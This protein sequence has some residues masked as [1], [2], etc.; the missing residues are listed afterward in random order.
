MNKKLGVKKR[1]MSFSQSYEYDVHNENG[2]LVR[3]ISINEWKEEVI[4]RVFSV[5]SECTW[6]IFHDKDT[7][8]VFDSDT[9][10]FVEE[11]V[12]IHYHGIFIFKN[13]R[14]MSSIAELIETEQIEH[15]RDYEGHLRYLT[16][17]TENAMADKKYRYGIDELYCSE[18]NKILNKEEVRKLYT[19][20]ISIFK[21]RK[22]NEL[23]RFVDEVERKIMNGELSN[24]FEIKELFIGK[25]GEV[26]NNH[27]RRY[28][29]RFNEAQEIYIEDR[30][31]FV[32]KRGRKLVT[33]YIY[34]KSNLGKTTLGEII[35]K[36]QSKRN[37]FSES[38]FYFGATKSE[39]ITKDVFQQYKSQYSTILDE[40]M[41]DEYFGYSQFNSVFNQTTMTTIGS[42]NVNRKW[43]SEFC[44]IIKSNGIDE[45]INNM[46]AKASVNEKKDME[47]V[48]KQ[49][50]RRIPI[51]VELLETGITV[52]VYDK[53]INDYVLKKEYKDLLILDS[54]INEINR[55]THELD[56]L[57]EEVRDNIKKDRHFEI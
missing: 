30:V 23:N 48:R 55:F 41:P 54:D 29:S 11:E 39:G 15:L 1:K 13:N 33:V 43:C 3:D 45:L 10:E 47:N 34:G 14:Y 46:C 7:K 31:K 53:K 19:E 21:N 20:N 16:H 6:L 52:K 9:N 26:G 49:V 40:F 50:M 35:A 24:D 4:E 32:E 8:K 22:N 5:E 2:E 27:Y 38:D 36:K 57:I 17:T 42:R 12:G 44:A 25:Y 37:S 56:L 51:T 18:N 28:K